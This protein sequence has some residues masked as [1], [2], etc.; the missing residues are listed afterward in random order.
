LVRQ[1]SAEYDAGTEV[2]YFM[3]DTLTIAIPFFKGQHYLRRALDSVLHQSSPNWQLIVVDDGTEGGTA[4]LVAACGDPRITYLKNER[5]LG[6]AGNWN[7]CLDVADTDLVNLLHNDDELLP[8]YVAEML[9][10]SRQFPDAAAFFCKAKVIDANGRESFSFVDFV[11]RF[12]QPKTSG[13]LVLEGQ[14]AIEALMHGDFIMCPTVCYRKSRL[15][16]ER[17]RSDWRQVLDLDFFT[18]ILL[19]GGT[20]VGLPVMAYTYRRHAE[21]ATTENTENL[22]RFDEESRLHDLIATIAQERGWPT[23]AGVAAGKRVIKLHLLFRIAQDLS[24]L[25]RSAALKKWQFLRGLSRRSGNKT[26]SRGIPST[27]PE[28]VPPPCAT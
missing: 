14:S 7:R 18:R 23:V 9:A 15:P 27:S 19:A 4:D 21:N 20:M 3:A 24:R 25:R 1:H 11:K 8:N 17:F 2:A 10:A 5:N 16:A 6:M 28:E 22:L 12:L 26:T 13:P